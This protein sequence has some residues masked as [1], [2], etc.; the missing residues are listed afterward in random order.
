VVVAE[1]WFFRDREPFNVFAQLALT[2]LR[3]RP[4]LRVL[5]LPC[6]SGEEPYSL[7]IALLD[8]GVPE[9]AFTIGAADLSA[10]ALARAE[11]AIYGKNSFRGR[12]LSF[13]DRHFLATK[14]G[15]ALSPLVRRCVAFEQTNLLD[16]GCLAQHAPYDFVFCRNLLIY[17]D[18]TTQILALNKLHQ[19]LADDGLLFVGPAELP[20]VVDSGFISTSHPMAFACYKAMGNPPPPATRKM[21]AGVAR[22]LMADHTAPA[23]LEVARQLAE[24]GH[25]T[26]A[27]A[28]CN[29]HLTSTGPSASVYFLL[30]L[31]KDAGNDPAAIPYYRKAL[32]LEP[33][34]YEALGH[35]AL[36]LEKAGELDAARIYKR[37]AERAQPKT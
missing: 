4:A 26:E 6:A 36:A 32:Y 35:L 34:H 1:T 33:N 23:K 25:L 7:A 22:P 14:D 30:G 28:I 11:R 17:F 16:D 12:E 24:A 19:L 21:P 15:Y 13:R 3:K 37:R 20:L 5:S 27:T 18:R 29:A 10:L 8:A 31:V 2:A 9:T